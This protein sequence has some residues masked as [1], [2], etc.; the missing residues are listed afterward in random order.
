MTT[1]ED[2][3]D[4]SDMEVDWHPIAKRI[5]SHCILAL[6]PKNNEQINETYNIHVQH[7]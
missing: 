6:N 5:G 3:Q 4:K 7:F 2:Y 1:F